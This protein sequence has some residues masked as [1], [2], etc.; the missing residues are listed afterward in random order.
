MRLVV[1]ERHS[2]LEILPGRIA[3]G[4]TIAVIIA[5][6]GV[7][8]SDD[9]EHGVAVVSWVLTEPS[10]LSGAFALVVCLR[11]ASRV[12]TVFLLARVA[13]RGDDEYGVAV[14]P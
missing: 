12:C 7:V 13:A 11:R 14:V 9:I 10:A 8:E 6:V 5:T 2:L 1:E 3:P 4:V